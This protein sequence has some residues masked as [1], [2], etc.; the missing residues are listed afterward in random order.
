MKVSSIYLYREFK[1]LWPDLRWYDIRLA[2]EN[3]WLPKQKDLEKALA[4][5]KVDRMKFI[6][7]INDCDDF[8]LQLHADIKRVRSFMAE[9]QQIPQEEWVS[10]AFGEVFGDKF[11]GMSMKHAANICATQEGMFLIEPREDRIWLANS[12]N[13]NI[14]FIKM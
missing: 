7:S 14:Y 13:D 2:D 6:N 3:Y 4:E 12:N 1:K 8:A 10:W 11:R 5:S 9:Y